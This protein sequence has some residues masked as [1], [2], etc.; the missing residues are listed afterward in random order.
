MEI[1]IDELLQGKATAIKDRNYFP[2]K[3]YVEP[4]LERMSQYTDDFR[5]QVKLPDQLAVDD[6][7]TINV[8]NRVVVQAVLPDNLT[9]SNHSQVVGMVYGI[10]VRKPVV[11]FYNGALDNVCTNLCVFSPEQLSCAALEPET[12]INYKPISHIMETIEETVTFIQKMK[13]TPFDCSEDS[14]STQLGY[15]VK[16]CLK[17]TFDIGYGKVKVASSTPVDAYKLLFE[18]TDSRYYIGGQESDMYNVYGA[19]TQIFTDNMKRDI[20]NVCE[21]TLLANKILGF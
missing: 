16:R 5:V 6:E 9:I 3:A 12:A 21:K 10:D 15:W 4:F 2:T 1:T 11:K 18:D 7:D 17:E 8:Y 13:N 20:M 19:F 14:T